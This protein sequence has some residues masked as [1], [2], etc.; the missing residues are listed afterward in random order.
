MNVSNPAR[1]LLK[2]WERLDERYGVPEL[3]KHAIVSKLKH[4]SVINS[5][6]SKKLYELVDILSE[7]EA[8]KKDSRYALQLS[9]FDSSEGML[10]IVQKLPY[11]IQEKWVTRAAYF[12]KNNSDRF[13]PFSYFLEFISDIAKIRNDPGLVSNVPFEKNT[14]T[15]KS[16]STTCKKTEIV[17][18]AAGK[19][20][21]GT[22]CPIH[23]PSH[24]LLDCRSF[25]AMSV[26]ERKK[27][28][29]DSR[30]CFKCL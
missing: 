20:D 7:V 8:L 10:P 15:P 29:K 6:E 2:I 11:N 1:E 26:S 5:K 16:I 21:L 9:Y 30:L 13:P 18:E 25:K 27:V 28:V 12:K 22:R 3:V 19:S 4:F 24:S 14:P 23:K 17:K